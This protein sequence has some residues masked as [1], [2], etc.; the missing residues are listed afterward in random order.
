MNP[1]HNFENP[2]NTSDRKHFIDLFKIKQVL[3]VY[4]YAFFWVI[5]KCLNFIC[6]HFR[7][8]C[9]FHLHRQVGMK[10]DWGW[11]CSGIYTRKGLAR[12]ISNFFDTSA[13]KIQ[14]PGNY[15]EESTQHS[16]HGKSLK[17]KADVVYYIVY[18]VMMTWLRPTH[19]KTSS[20]IPLP[21]LLSKKLMI[22]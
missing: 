5:P 7:T 20:K 8:F 19:P 6:Q 18:T 16:E 10:N 15:P 9:L 4:V 13:H 2:L 22:K 11:E 3:Y 21:Y 1:L 17:S 12:K 14:T